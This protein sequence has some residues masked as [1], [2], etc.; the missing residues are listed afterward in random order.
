AHWI[1]IENGVIAQ[2]TIIS[3]TTWNASPKDDNDQRG[4]I[5]QALVG[6]K[7]RDPENPFEIVRIVR[8]FDPCLACAVHMLIGRTGARKRLMVV[9]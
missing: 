7:V 8:S 4:P 5:E 1:R 9:G 6:T 3:P 2:Y